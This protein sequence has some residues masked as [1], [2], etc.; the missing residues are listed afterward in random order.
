VVA[1]ILFVALALFVSRAWLSPDYQGVVTSAGS[2]VLI[3]KDDGGFECASHMM[4]APATDATIKRDGEAIEWT[5]I[6]VGDHVKVWTNG[7]VDDSCPA[8]AGAQ[9]IEI[10]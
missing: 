10:D 2:W 1:I 6:Q 7:Q 5:D 9:R 8:E 3:E 4:F